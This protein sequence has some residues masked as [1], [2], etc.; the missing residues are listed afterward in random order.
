MVL[1][2]MVLLIAG[3]GCTNYQIPGK[4]KIDPEPQANYC[5]DCHTDYDRL[6]EVHSPDTAPPVGGCGGEAP[7]YEPYDRVYLGGEGYEAFKLSG[8]YNIGCTGCHNGDGNANDKDAAH[9][10]DWISHPSGFYEEKCASCHSDITDVFASSLHNG[11]G[12][13]R[14]Q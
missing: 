3:I 9:S 10:D 14:Y 5:E 12:Q 6:V 7:H 13:K 8:H 2:F 4:E 1:I 11:T